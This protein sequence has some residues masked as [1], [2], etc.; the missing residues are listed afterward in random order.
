MR[1]C[2]GTRRTQLQAMTL[3]SCSSV[4]AEETDD[5]DVNTIASRL[6]IACS[7]SSMVLGEVV[8]SALTLL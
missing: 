2:R 3:Q 7:R 5:R 8:V 4:R 6:P 1:D